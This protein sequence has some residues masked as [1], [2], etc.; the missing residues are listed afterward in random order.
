VPLSWLHTLLH[1]PPLLPGRSY[2]QGEDIWLISSPSP[3]MGAPPGSTA[4][5]SPIPDPRSLRLLS[6]PDPSSPADII[7]FLPER[8]MWGNTPL[9]SIRRLK[10][11]ALP[12]SPPP[13]VGYWSHLFPDLPDRK[14]WK[15]LWSPNV[16]PSHTILQL[17]LLHGK[18][19]SGT[20]ADRIGF[21]PPPLLCVCG[22][23]ESSF[24]LFWECPFA[25]KCWKSL[26]A[27]SPSAL[28]PPF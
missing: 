28:R 25:Q 17:K 2:L 3:A 13:S 1:P 26:F 10:A 23:R 16:P 18:V 14:T 7:S 12:S 9:M 6:L 22:H 15:H 27:C 20:R 4:P 8:L 21:S 24:H 11:I 5:P 19:W